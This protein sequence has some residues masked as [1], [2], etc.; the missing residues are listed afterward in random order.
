MMPAC[1]LPA[2]RQGRQSARMFKDYINHVL[3]SEKH[4]RSIQ[5]LNLNSFL[6]KDG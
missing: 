2:G 1:R 3:V 6:N 5:G 4:A